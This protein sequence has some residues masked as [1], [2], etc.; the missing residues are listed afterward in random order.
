M[1]ELKYVQ[2]QYFSLR[3]APCSPCNTSDQVSETYHSL[4]CTGEVKN[5]WAHLRVAM[6]WWE[7]RIQVFTIC[8]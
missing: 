7:A 2:S 6:E 1:D 8:G 3:F 5:T 4:P